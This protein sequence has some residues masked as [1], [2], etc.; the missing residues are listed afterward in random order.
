[1]VG[2]LIEIQVERKLELTFTLTGNY[3]NMLN[4]NADVITF[5]RSRIRRMYVLIFILKDMVKEI[6]PIYILY[7]SLNLTYDVDFVVIFFS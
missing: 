1:M 3:F 4:G 6:F 7:C 2:K 5:F